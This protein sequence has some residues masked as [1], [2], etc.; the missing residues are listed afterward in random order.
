MK[1][2]RQAN[3]TTAVAV[4]EQYQFREPSQEYRLFKV[5]N[6]DSEDYNHCM[7]VCAF[8]RTVSVPEKQSCFRS[9]CQCPT[10]RWPVC[11]P[12]YLISCR[13]LPLLPRGV[14]LRPPA[15]SA[16]SLLL[17]PSQL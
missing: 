6:Y 1:E 7:Y 11:T 2:D 12:S 8:V 5:T 14:W 13:P 3:D 9:Q 17:L 4:E 15:P 16:P 10:V